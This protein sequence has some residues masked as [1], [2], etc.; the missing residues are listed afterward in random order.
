MLLTSTGR[1]RNSVQEWLRLRKLHLFKGKWGFI[2]KY[3]CK[4]KKIVIQLKIRF[5]PRRIP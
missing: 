4:K 1:T 2:Y 3:I 5:E